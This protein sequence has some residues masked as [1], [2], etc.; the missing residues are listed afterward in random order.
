[1]LER[2]AAGA[3]E[4]GEFDSGPGAYFVDDEVPK[5]R[6]RRGG[7]DRAQEGSAVRLQGGE[8][9]RDAEFRCVREDGALRGLTVADSV[10]KLRDDQRL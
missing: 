10:V 7:A 3:Q 2:T 6:L 5:G 8:A 4:L 1:M 9:T